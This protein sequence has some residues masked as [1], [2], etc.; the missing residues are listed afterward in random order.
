MILTLVV[1]NYN[2][3]D[4]KGFRFY[5]PALVW[6]KRLDPLKF[7]IVRTPKTYIMN[8]FRDISKVPKNVH[9]PPPQI[10]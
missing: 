8:V 2:R 6:V 7:K 9:L 5:P 3:L 4:G 10:G 1:F